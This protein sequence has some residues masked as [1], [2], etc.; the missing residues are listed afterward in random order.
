[1]RDCRDAE[2]CD[3]AAQR[4]AFGMCPEEELGCSL[5]ELLSSFE[6]VHGVA[7]GRQFTC[8]VVTAGGVRCWGRNHRGQLGYGHTGNIGDLELPVS[9]GNV[10]VGGPVAQI[11][12]GFS[13]TCA[14]FTNGDVSCWGYAGSGQLGYGDVE[15]RKHFAELTGV[16]ADVGDDETPVCCRA[17]RS[18]RPSHSAC[19]GCTTL[20]ARSCWEAT[21]AAGAKAYDGALG[22]ADTEDIGDDETPASMDPVNLGGPAAFI[23]AGAYHSCAILS[24]G[25]VR[26]WGRALYG[27]L[28]YGNDENIGDDEPPASAGSV[29]LHEQRHRVVRQR[30]A[31]L[32]G[33]EQRV[34]ALLGRRSRSPAGPRRARNCRR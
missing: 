28:G 3:R 6:G 18:G 13:H 12:A 16:S 5:G 19:R 10:D 32:C 15:R 20:R 30:N 29:A 23:T 1:M 25:E 33:L 9:A 7:L 21:Y 26:C 8:A 14:L 4:C 11:A 31:H 27:G 2:R 24:T 17:P 22:Y 34:A